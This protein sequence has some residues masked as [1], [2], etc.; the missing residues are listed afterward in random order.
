MTF[1]V[2]EKIKFRCDTERMNRNISIRAIKKECL[3]Q[4]ELDK[5]I[6]DIKNKIAIAKKVSK[7]KKDKSYILSELSH[8]Q[9]QSL[10]VRKDNWGDHEVP[11]D[12]YEAKKVR[13]S[14]PKLP[15]EIANKQLREFVGELVNDDD[16]LDDLEI[17]LDDGKIT[18]HNVTKLIKDH[19]KKNEGLVTKELINKNGDIRK[20]IHYNLTEGDFED[21]FEEYVSSD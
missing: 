11:E 1:G 4:Q 13:I 5:R 20:V 21:M 19:C 16:L 6:T 12:E 17:E 9:V 10:V 2:I 14:K 8:N 18:T 15:S 7:N 3:I